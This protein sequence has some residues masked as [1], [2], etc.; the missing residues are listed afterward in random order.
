MSKSVHLILR[1]HKIHGTRDLLLKASASRELN[2]RLQDACNA[3][4]I[5][6]PLMHKINNLQGD[7][8]G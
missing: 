3:E 7:F 5:S 4:I 1:F 8:A 6:A 2:V